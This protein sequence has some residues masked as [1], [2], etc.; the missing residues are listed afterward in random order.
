[1]TR[2]VTAAHESLRLSEHGSTSSEP[3]GTHCV[4]AVDSD[5]NVLFESESC[6]S[7]W[8]VEYARNNQPTGEWPEAVDHYEV[9]ER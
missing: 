1:M 4:V 9:R 6:T 3:V 7:E 5:G 8:A 2:K